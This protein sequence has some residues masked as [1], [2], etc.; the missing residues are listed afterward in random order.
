[1]ITC[2]GALPPRLD[3]NHPKNQNF[4]EKKNSF[5][6][7]I[8]NRFLYCRSIIFGLNF[9]FK[10]RENDNNGENFFGRIRIAIQSFLMK[11]LNRF[12]DCRSIIFGKK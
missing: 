12:L 6:M 8:L 7:R 3:L 9:F 10:T 4:I 5:Q 11:I 1:M 2:V